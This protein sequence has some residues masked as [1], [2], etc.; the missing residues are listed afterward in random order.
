MRSRSFLKSKGYRFINLSSGWEST[1]YIRYADEN[2]NYLGTVSEFSLMLMNTSLLRVF[3]IFKQKKIIIS[4]TFSKLAELGKKNKPKFV[5]AHMLAPHPPN[6]FSPNGDYVECETCDLNDWSAKTAYV[7]EIQF[8]NEKILKLTDRII[9]SSS[10]PP[11]IVVQADHGPA[12]GLKNRTLY[13]EDWDNPG[14]NVKEERTGILN[15]YFLNKDCH[16]FLYYSISPVN[17]FRVI[18]NCYFKTNYS[19]LEDKVYWSHPKRIV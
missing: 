18:L 12:S 9:K 5:L 14:L 16:K 13:P 19:L 11:V 8:I 4:R 1:D 6:I 2:I 7:D 17:S 3:E 10:I 15:L